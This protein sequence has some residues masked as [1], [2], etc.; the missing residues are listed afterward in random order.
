MYSMKTFLNDKIQRHPNYQN[1]ISLERL[2]KSWI[3]FIENF[4]NF[5]KLIQVLKKLCVLT[6]F[7]IDYEIFDMLGKG[8]FA[9]VYS[10]KNKVNQQFYAA[11]IFNKESDVIKK[12]IVI[13]LIF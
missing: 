12:N 9:E 4:D 5:L 7:S 1:Y 3:F 8:H 13:L 2:Q 10:V 6:N 11:K